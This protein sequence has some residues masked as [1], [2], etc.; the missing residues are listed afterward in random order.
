MLQCFLFITAQVVW[1]EWVLCAS[2]CAPTCLRILHVSHNGRRC[3]Q[4]RHLWSWERGNTTLSF[5]A[6]RFLDRWISK[7][8]CDAM[9]I[10]KCLSFFSACVPIWCLLCWNITLRGSP[11]SEGTDLRGPGLGSCFPTALQYRLFLPGY[12]T[13]MKILI[14]TIWLRLDSVFWLIDTTQPIMSLRYRQESKQTDLLNLQ[15]APAPGHITLMLHR[16]R[17]Y[18]RWNRFIFFL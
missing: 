1:S 8:L 13:S 12:A 14:T 5:H 4:W 15:Q 7:P 9:H 3:V 17:C 2:S 6:I 16:E 10:P 11:S 18:K